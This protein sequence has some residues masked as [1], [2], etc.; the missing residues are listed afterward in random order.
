MKIFGFADL[1]GQCP[2]LPHALLR[3][4]AAP[5]GLGCHEVTGGACPFSVIIRKP[6]PCPVGQRSE[7]PR[8]HVSHACAWQVQCPTRRSKSSQ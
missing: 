6:M 3:E 8:P 4:E 5:K 7:E 2:F 1:T